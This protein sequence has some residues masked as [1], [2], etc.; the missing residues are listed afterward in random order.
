M[1]FSNLILIDNA[2]GFGQYIRNVSD[3]NEYLDQTTTA[4]DITIYGETESLDCPLAG[5]DGF[6]F[7]IEKYGMNTH[8][9]CTVG[10]TV[11][12]RWKRHKPWKRQVKQE[13]KEI[14]RK[15]E[16]STKSFENF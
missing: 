8:G 3:R 9:G 11:S 7:M 16:T 14:G 6:C 13:I 1:T 12:G 15:L 2:F 10:K 4:S 5:A